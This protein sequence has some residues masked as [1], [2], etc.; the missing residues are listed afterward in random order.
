MKPPRHLNIFLPPTITEANSVSP[1][2]DSPLIIPVSTCGNS[3]ALEIAM[4]SIC[5][6]LKGKAKASSTDF[7]QF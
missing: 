2:H 1:K 3:I 7:S 4:M 6:P 5:T